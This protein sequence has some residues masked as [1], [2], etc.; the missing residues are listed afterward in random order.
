MCRKA[1]RTLP[2]GKAPR[3]SRVECRADALPAAS[4]KNLRTELPCN[5]LIPRG[6]LWWLACTSTT[7]LATS[8]EK[9]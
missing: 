1:A 7:V 6:R 8:Q 5:S 4:M 2:N 9:Q 3:I